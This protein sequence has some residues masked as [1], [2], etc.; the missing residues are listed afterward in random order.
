ML[1]VTAVAGTEAW[2]DFYIA[3]S[4]D[5]RLSSP[6]AAPQSKSVSFLAPQDIQAPAAPRSSPQTPGSGSSPLAPKAPA[7]PV[8]VSQASTF[9]SSA[10]RA[11][12]FLVAGKAPTAAT[13]SAT[14]SVERT[15]Q[16]PSPHGSASQAAHQPHLAP[17]PQSKPPGLGTQT[18]G[19]STQSPNQSQQSHKPA[20]QPQRPSDKLADP[21]LS[22]KSPAPAPP[23]QIKQTTGSKHPAKKTSKDSNPGT[24]SQS[25]IKKS[26]NKGPGPKDNT[27]KTDPKPKKEILNSNPISGAAKGAQTPKV[28]KPKV[29]LYPLQTYLPARRPAP[30]EEVGERAPK[31]AKLPLDPRPLLE[32]LRKPRYTAALCQQSHWTN[33]IREHSQDSG[34]LWSGILF[35]PQLNIAVMMKVMYRSWASA[36]QIRSLLKAQHAMSL[37]RRVSWDLAH[38]SLP[39]PLISGGG[40]SKRTECICEVSAP[41]EHWAKLEEFCSSLRNAKSAGMIELGESERWGYLIPSASPYHAKVTPGFQRALMVIV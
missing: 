1:K 32:I 13:P 41:P 38:V 27:E 11:H 15:A 21:S 28:Q 6:T 17:D 36:A 5:Q 22:D 4:I 24:Q 33:T 16:A 35:G 3:F 34:S 7:V 39:A 12:V 18:P 23:P 29:N 25:P 19:A 20:S 8:P 31:C 30:G 40:A 2:K 14:P 10:P 9:V 26:P 37:C